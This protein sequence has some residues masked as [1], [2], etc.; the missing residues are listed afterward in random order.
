MGERERLVEVVYADAGQVVPC[1]VQY[2]KEGQTE[3]LWRA[4]HKAGY[5]ERKTQWFIKKLRRLGWRL[6]S[7]QVVNIAR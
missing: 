7:D 6:Q 3:V 2:Q 5:C 1:E 4:N